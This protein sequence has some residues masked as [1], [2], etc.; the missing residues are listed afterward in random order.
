M[1]RLLIA[2]DFLSLKALLELINAKNTADGANSLLKPYL[3]QKGINL[4]AQVAIGVQAKG[5]DDSRQLLFKQSTNY[6]Q[7]RDLTFDPIAQRLKAEV[8]FLKGLYKP[9]VNA[10]GD[11][12]IEVVNNSRINYPGSFDDMSA[13]AI[14]FF[15]K[16]LSYPTGTSPLQPYITKNGINITTDRAAVLTAQDYAAKSIA[17]AKASQTATEQRDNLWQPVTEIIKG[18]GDYLF[19]LYGNNTKGLGDWGF[20][21]DNSGAKPKEIKT[22]LVLGDKTTIKGLL[23]GSVLTNIGKID[24]HVYKGS[25]T[26]GNPIIIHAGE[27]FGIAKGFNTITVSNPSELE[28]AEFT[29]VRSN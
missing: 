20:V 29:T 26:M 11:W 13:L 15:D 21:V 3:T 10:L 12:N 17:S 28:T 18:M 6:T 8:Q 2:T 19:N 9:N 22:K 7:L 25:T 5:F 23:I 1:A 16:H 14:K 27:K 24:I 4:P